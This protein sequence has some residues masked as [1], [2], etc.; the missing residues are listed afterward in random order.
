MTGR[1][2]DAERRSDAVLGSGCRTQG[3]RRD[4]AG[5]ALSTGNVNSMVPERCRYRAPS[6]RCWLEATAAVG[7]EPTFAGGRYAATGTTDGSD[8]VPTPKLPDAAR[9]VP[10]W[11]LTRPLDV[12]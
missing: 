2:R 1:L 8:P 12:L 9:A 4:D 3:N 7:Q 6:R 11:A 10:S 5:R